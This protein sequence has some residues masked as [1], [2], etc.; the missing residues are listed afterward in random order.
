[1]QSNPPPV[2]LYISNQSEQC[3]SDEV[4]CLRYTYTTTESQLQKEACVI[5]WALTQTATAQ[6]QKS[7]YLF[8]PMFV[9]I[10]VTQSLSNNIIL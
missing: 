1:M 4:W 8:H 7:Q 10:S 3:V 2:I 6:A 9:F 5:Q